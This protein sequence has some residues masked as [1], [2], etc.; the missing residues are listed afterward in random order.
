MKLSNNLLLTQSLSMTK[1]LSTAIALLSKSHTE[2]DK[3]VED[4]LTKNPCLRESTEDYW[5]TGPSS[6]TSRDAV[7]A[8]DVALST[9]GEDHDFRDRLISELGEHR[10]NVIEMSIATYLIHSLDDDGL[11]KDFDEVAANLFDMHGY[12][13][14]WVESL[15]LKIMALE[16]LGCGAKSINES[17]SYQLRA[18]CDKDHPQF[19]ALLKKLDSDPHTKINLSSLAGLNLDS[20]LADL[21]KL[22]ARP[23]HAH[24]DNKI[25]DALHIPELALHRSGENL[26][27]S[28]TK[29]A[30]MRLVV[31]GH[32]HNKHAASAFINKK[33]A[34][35]KF[36]CGALKHREQS[37]LRVAKTIAAHQ[38]GF[39]VDRAPLKP[40]TLAD[41]A[42]DA[43]LSESSVSRLVRNKYMSTDI[44][45]F[46]LKFFFNSKISSNNQEG[47]HSSHTIKSV[48]LN[49]V[50]SEDKKNPHSDQKISQDLASS[51]FKIS[52]R[53]VAKYRDQL[54]IGSCYERRVL[55]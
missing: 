2:I 16:P 44:G 27:V 36:L 23:A 4:E 30:S 53:T 42:A 7:S 14:E 45:V 33:L 6:N 47:D 21:R 37:L 28:L 3:L 20:E 31:E 22:H 49:L 1:D 51:G 55:I 43:S 9:I 13:H 35:A 11:L 41:I 40:L 54:R 29:R 46:E 48:L 34:Q 24:A 39:L 10:L 38:H 18:R 26:L 15:R 19:I 25:T 17:L 52:R 8:Y 12:Y 50:K 32:T 5:Y